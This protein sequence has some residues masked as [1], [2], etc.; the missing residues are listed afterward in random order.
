MPTKTQPAV[1]DEGPVPAYQR[2]KNHVIAQ[3]QKGVWGEGDLIPTEL[4]LC[5]QFGVSRM[6]AHRAL[7]ELTGAGLLVRQQGSGTYVAPIKIA[8]TLI[9]IRSI[10]QDIRGRGH[11]HSCRVVSLQT[12]VASAEQ[13]SR[14]GLRVRA[15]LFRSVIVHFENGTPIQLEDRVVDAARMPDYL[16]QDWSQLTPNEYLMHAA[17]APTGYYSIE[18]K[19][20][21]ADVAGALNVPSSEPCLVLERTTLSNGAFASHAVMWYPGSRYKLAGQIPI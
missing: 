12:V 1:R 16:D 18:V 21:T 9:E 14:L 3:I 4:M 17:P 2:I 19:L 5:E 6:T 20:P 10:A 8:S 7:R 11:Q 13:S 15:K